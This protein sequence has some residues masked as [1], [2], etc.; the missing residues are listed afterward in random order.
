[1]S[2]LRSGPAAVPIRAWETTRR[3]RTSSG[4]V[5][6]AVIQ[7]RLTAVLRTGLSPFAMGKQSRAERGLSQRGCSPMAESTRTL[8]NPARMP[9]RKAR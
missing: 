7:A 9:S 1:M 6:S 5:F 4:S 8:P 2:A 3:S